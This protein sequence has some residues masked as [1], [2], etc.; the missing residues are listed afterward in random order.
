MAAPYADATVASPDIAD[1]V[2]ISDR[3]LYIIGKKT[4]STNV[5]I[6]DQSKRLI[7][8]LDVDVQLDTQAFGDKVRQGSGGRGIRVGEINGNVVVSG[9][10]GDAQTAERAMRVAVGLAGEGRG[11][12]N[13]L[14][15]SAP[16]QVELQVRFVE[17]SRSAVRN[18]GVRWQSFWRNGASG[19]VVGDQQSTSKL[20]AISSNSNGALDVTS[21]VT[22][23]ASPFATILTQIVNSKAGGLDVVLS[24]L[25]EQQ[26]IRRLAQP[27]LVASSGESADFLAGGEFPVPVSSA[28]TAGIPT[29]TVAYK[30]FGVKLRFTPTVLADG[31]ISL[32]LEPEVSELDSTISVSTGGVTV[33]GI[34]KRRAN[35]TVQL[36]DGQSFAIAGML[37]AQSQR[38]VDALPWLGTVPVLGSLFSS[39]S[40]QEQETELVV[41]VSPHLVV[42]VPPG[43]KLKTPLDAS[44]PANDVDLFLRGKLEVP[45]SPPTNATASGRQRILA[46]GVVPVV[47][48]A[49]P[50]HVE[51]DQWRWPW[52]VK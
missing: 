23:A 44:L 32:K 50:A 3:Q 8:V 39:K 16:Q 6:Y 33:P 40:F 2:P 35:T 22:G 41:I 10:A 49:A 43:R 42:P 18:L 52:E 51:S 15:V 34:I 26:V 12:V 7:G 28:T 29:I 9:D 46:G 5:L 21:G 37:S 17:A 19:A 11:V 14:R 24:A 30:E 20:S 47:A 25:E 1:V 27:N 48:P 13:A 31:V 45:K 36:R 38:T 4:G